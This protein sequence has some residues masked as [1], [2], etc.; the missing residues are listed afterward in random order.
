MELL[1]AGVGGC[2]SVYFESGFEAGEVVALVEWAEMGLG[3]DGSSD[4][5]A[6]TLGI[7][8]GVG[9]GFG[10]VFHGAMSRS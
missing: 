8:D 4:A 1:L 7:D 10:F 9:G 2:H 3:F 5:F 6:E